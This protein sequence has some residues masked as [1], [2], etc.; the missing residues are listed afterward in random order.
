MI[1]QESTQRCSVEER[2]D[3]PI[4]RT[5]Q[6]TDETTKVISWERVPGHIVEQIVCVPAPQMKEKKS[7]VIQV[8]PHEQIQEQISQCN[9]E[10]IEDVFGASNHGDT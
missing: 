2:M 9:V 6:Q 3:L 5:Q 10:E 4:S 7:E 1:Q 8:V